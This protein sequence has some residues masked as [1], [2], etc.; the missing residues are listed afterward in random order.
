[1]GKTKKVGRP[2]IL[3]DAAIV[4][5]DSRA[6][7]SRLQDASDRRAVVNRVIDLGGKTTV[8]ALNESFGY[9][10][11]AI[12]LALNKVNWLGVEVPKAS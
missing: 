7:K 9:D 8:G 2:F 4:F 6:A 12:V 5:V 11:R 1:M 10:V 3:E